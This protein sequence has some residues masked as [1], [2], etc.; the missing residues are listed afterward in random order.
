MSFVPVKRFESA[1]EP[2][3]F[4]TSTRNRHEPKRILPIWKITKHEDT[5]CGNMLSQG[6][7][8]SNVMDVPFLG[9]PVSTPSNLDEYLKCSRPAGR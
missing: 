2:G 7:G 5:L 4:P 9:D 8:I 6:I 1:V 3:G